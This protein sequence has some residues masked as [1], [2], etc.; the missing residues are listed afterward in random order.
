MRSG[1]EEDCCNSNDAACGKKEHRIN[2][3]EG[4][5]EDQT[6]LKILRTPDWCA[7]LSS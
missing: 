4:W 3:L 1:L 2:L 6:F 5:K 7:V